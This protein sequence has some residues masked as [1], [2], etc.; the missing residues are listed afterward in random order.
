[1]SYVP[2]DDF[3]EYKKKLMTLV[4]SGLYKEITINTKGKICGIYMLYVDNFED[5]KI[6]PVYI[7]Q[8]IDIVQRY[9]SH[10]SEIY[11]INRFKY[12]TYAWNM[13]RRMYEGSYKAC[14][15]FSYMV[16]HDCK[17]SDLK[18]ILLED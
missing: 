5:D 10:V 16:N 9:K 2:K 17:L 15:I 1:M 14:K 13:L 12:I 11:T 4:N 8:S 6:I 3:I 7:G 18:M